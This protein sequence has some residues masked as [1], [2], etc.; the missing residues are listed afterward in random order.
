M[1]V[2]RI[3]K[4]LG[5]FSDWKV[6]SEKVCEVVWGTEVRYSLRKIIELFRNRLVMYLDVAEEFKPLILVQ[7]RIGVGSDPGRVVVGWG[8]VWSRSVF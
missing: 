2:E 8:R 5:G 4:V 7:G 1:E 6:P 3:A